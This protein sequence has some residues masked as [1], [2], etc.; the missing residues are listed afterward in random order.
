MYIRRHCP[1][2]TPENSVFVHGPFWVYDQLINGADE[3]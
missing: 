1:K 3:L 2:A